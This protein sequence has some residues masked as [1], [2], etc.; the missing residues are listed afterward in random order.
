MNYRPINSMEFKNLAK[1]TGN[2]HLLLK[3]K[4]NEKLKVQNEEEEN[5]V[6]VSIYNFFNKK[7]Q[8]VQELKRELLEAFESDS[9]LGGIGK[10]LTG[11][12]YIAP[13][14]V[15]AQLVCLKKALPKLKK[16]LTKTFFANLNDEEEIFFN[17][18]DGLTSSPYNKLS[19]KI[20]GQIVQERGKFFGKIS[21]R[22]SKFLSPSQWHEKISKKCSNRIII[23][24][25]NDYETIIGSFR[26]SIKPDT[27]RYSQTFEIVD[28]L[29]KNEPKSKEILLFCTGGIRCEKVSSHIQNVRGF[30]N[31]SSLKGG[32][33]AYKNWL[34]CENVDASLFDG[35][36]FVFD[37]RVITS[38]G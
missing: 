8:N 25:R 26:G 9:S 1:V 36:L 17:I 16:I 5:L 14:G 30:E 38:V 3:C 33:V 29:I 32:V 31:V 23:D 10:G 24:C 2:F 19:I 11:S 12:C 21:S 27:Q 22:N 6:Q 15:N 18:G 20:K 13:E 28:N 4:L 35:D 37:K 7:P 34:K